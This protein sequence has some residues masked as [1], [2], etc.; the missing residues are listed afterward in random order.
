[1]IKPWKYTVRDEN[2]NVE[3]EIYNHERAAEYVGVHFPKAENYPR[4][5]MLLYARGCFH[6]MRLCDVGYMLMAYSEE[7][8]EKFDA[9]IKE[10]TKDG[11]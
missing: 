7:E 11:K 5:S 6:E 4:E 1:M 9:F 2:G 10:V 3:M 8:F